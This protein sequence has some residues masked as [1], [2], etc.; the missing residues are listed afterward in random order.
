MTR[1]QNQNVG[2]S[3]TSGITVIIIS[4]IVRIAVSGGRFAGAEA[5]ADAFGNSASDV[6]VA[7]AN[8]RLVCAV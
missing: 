3:H 6:D 2:M 7:T 1:V 8:L 5:V 4:I